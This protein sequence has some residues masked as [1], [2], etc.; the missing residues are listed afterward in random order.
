MMNEIA[1]NKLDYKS[2]KEVKRISEQ[3]LQLQ[4]QKNKKKKEREDEEKVSNFYMQS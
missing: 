4:D 1:L 2:V 3:S